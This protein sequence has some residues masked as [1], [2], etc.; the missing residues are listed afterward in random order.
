MDR[1]DVVAEANYAIFGDIGAETAAVD[2]W[3]EESGSGEVLEG[4]RTVRPAGGTLA[5]PR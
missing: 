2:E 3:A 5:T 1:S 4:G